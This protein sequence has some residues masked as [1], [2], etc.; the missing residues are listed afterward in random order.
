MKKVWIIL[1][2]VLIVAAATVLGLFAAGVFDKNGEESTPVIA[3]AVTASATDAGVFKDLAQDTYF[4]VKMPSATLKNYVSV[5]DNRKRT[6]GMKIK[7]VISAEEGI[8]RITAENGFE[9]RSTYRITL[10]GASFVAEQYKDLKTFI[11]TIKGDEEITP[12]VEQNKSIIETDISGT[13]VEPVE[14]TPGT[15]YYNVTLASAAESRFAPGTVFL[16]KKP[17]DD[18]LSK[19]FSIL[20]NGKIEGYLYENMAAYVALEESEVVDGKEKI[21]CRLA[22][23][24]EVIEKADIYQDIVIDEKNFDFDE[25]AIQEALENSEFAEVLLAT[26]QQAYDLF[27]KSFKYEVNDGKKGPRQVVTFTVG[28]DGNKVILDIKYTITIA[29]GVNVVVG[30][31]NTVTLRPSL[32]CDYDISSGEFDLEFDFSVN[33]DTVTECTVTM[34]TAKG[35]INCATVEEFKEKFV[36][37]LKMNTN[38]KAICGAEIPIYSYK[39]PIYCFVLGVEFGVDLNFNISGDLSFGYTYNTNIVAGVTY[40]DDEFTSYKSMETSQSA[41]DLVLLGKVEARAGVYVKLTA[42][43]LEVVGIGFKIKVGAYAELGGQLRL[44]MQAALNKELHVVKGY[45]IT[46]GLYLGADFQVKA[47]IDIPVIGYKGIDKTW[48]IAEVKYPLFEYGSKYLPTEILDSGKTI[49]IYGKSVE[50]SKVNVKAFNLY[51]AT[52]VSS[53]ELPLDRFDIVYI[54]DAADYITLKDGYVNVKPTV[55]V[56]FNAT[57]ELVS[58]SD[59]YVK[60]RVTFHKSAIMPTCEETTAVFDKNAPSDVVFDVSLNTSTYLGLS[61]NGT[62]VTKGISVDGTGKITMYSTYL[63]DLAVGEH[64]F[65]YKSNRGVVYLTVNVVNSEPIT[66]SGATKSYSKRTGGDVSFDLDLKGNK[67]ASVEGLEPSQYA[68]GSS[69]KVFRIFG[70]VFTNKEVGAYNYRVTAANGR[71]VDITVNVIDDRL[72]KLYS[73]YFGFH[74]NSL[75]KVDVNVPFE[76][77]AYVVKSVIGPNLHTYD[78]VCTDGNLCISKDYLMALDAGEQKFEIVLS[79]KNS[80]LTL[81]FTVDVRENVSLI[82]G[83]SY[84]VFDKNAPKDVEYIIYASSANVTVDGL[85]TSKYS[86]S[87]NLLTINKNY[88]STLDLGENVLTVHMGDASLELTLKV[89]DTGEPEIALA[90]GGKLYLTYDKATNADISFDVRLGSASFDRIDDSA[91]RYSA[92]TENG[93]TKVTLAASYLNSLS[94]GEHEYDVLTTVN[95]MTLVLK[96]VDSSTPAPNGSTTL[97]Y[98]KSSLGASDLTVYFFNYGCDIVSIEAIGSAAPALGEYTFDVDTGIFTLTKAYLDTLTEGDYTSFA[99]TFNDTNATTLNINV[100]VSVD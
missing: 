45:Y 23:F 16:A 84:A 6:V 26:A 79:G 76:Q 38:E 91:V 74:K 85:S 55:G 80:E 34:D 50:Y 7:Q 5:T 54:D 99:L 96:V 17:G 20:Y 73:N 62:A 71:Y 90:N 19:D 13:T 21:Y 51:S 75:N 59:S 4:D 18:I 86:F 24:N 93:V 48:P 42:S 32:N 65:T 8:Y 27:E 68:V 56:E 46:G 83:S 100:A 10:Y 98:V 81:K 58:K 94:Y 66:V 63:K 39:Y 3:N 57:I 37:L 29:K 77:Y 70:A 78:Y 97:S 82:A 89:I 35:T 12:V 14:P 69:G 47:G 40:V 67:V 2:I 41:N 60:G 52:D 49:Q 43:V 30:I 72:P 44:D 1:P 22:Y 61:L 33:I 28:L 31:K 87:G 64:V 15:T 53:I 11:F 92:V 95:R 88:L 9:E 25:F 36:E